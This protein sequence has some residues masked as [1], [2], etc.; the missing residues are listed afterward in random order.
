M[1]QNKGGEDRKYIRPSATFFYSKAK[2][3][4]WMTQVRILRFFY[5][6]SFYL[7][8]MLCL[9]FRHI[10]PSVKTTLNKKRS[11]VNTVY[12]LFPQPKRTTPSRLITWNT[13]HQSGTSQELWFPT[14]LRTFLWKNKYHSL[15]MSALNKM[16]RKLTITLLSK[17]H[18]LK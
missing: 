2:L 12:K 15:Q 14:G 10:L 13:I 11:N 18:Y 5:L 16:N 1:K 6:T 9:S 7:K 4:A 3:V 17:L 8:R